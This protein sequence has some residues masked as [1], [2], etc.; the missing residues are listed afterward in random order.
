MFAPSNSSGHASYEG[1][2]TASPFSSQHVLDG[3][4]IKP[5]IVF[6]AVQNATG[7][8]NLLGHGAG[9][10]ALAEMASSEVCALTLDAND[11]S[12]GLLWYP[13]PGIDWNASVDFAVDWSESGTGASGSATFTLT[14]EAITIDTTAISTSVGASS[15]GTAITADAPS[16]TANCFQRS[17]W[18][19]I[20]A[21]TL[22]A[23][24][25]TVVYVVNVKVTLATIADASVYALV[26]RFYRRYI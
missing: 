22:S 8:A 2:K 20:T 13:E 3:Q 24:C 21:A 16:A 23:D 11:E 19:K 6:P 10:P 14:Y 9:T 1:L 17:P 4:I 26:N 15:L 5:L 18:G 25:D 7:P 12:F